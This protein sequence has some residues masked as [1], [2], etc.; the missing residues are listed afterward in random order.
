[1]NRLLGF[2]AAQVGAGGRGAIAR[3]GVA[4]AEVQGDASHD[5]TGAAETRFGFAAERRA[6][7]VQ[8]RPPQVWTLPGTGPQEPLFIAFGQE[9]FVAGLAQLLGLLGAA[10]L[11]VG[12][13]YG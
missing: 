9:F 6:R 2:T 3:L 10:A 7:D 1:M 5:P 8:M 11:E 12:D 13:F 4:I